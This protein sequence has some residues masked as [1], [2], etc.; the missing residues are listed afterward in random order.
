MPFFTA[1]NIDSANRIIQTRQPDKWSYEKKLDVE[2]QLG[3][4]FYKKSK[5]LFD[6]GHMV[7]RLDPCWGQRAAQAEIETFKF[8]NCVP[9]HSRLNRT[10]W[11][12]LEKNILEKGAI[13]KGGRI[14]VFAGPIFGEEEFYAHI[15]QKDIVFI[16]AMYWKIIVWK[17]RDRKLY[18]VGFVMSQWEFLKHDLKRTSTRSEQEADQYYENLKF[19]NDASYQVDIRAIQSLSKLRFPWKNVNYPY[20]KNTHTQLDVVEI[21][22]GNGIRNKKAGGLNFEILNLTL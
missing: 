6:K 21:L 19:K 4:T 11:L 7:R 10:I 1:V 17:K 16:P 2:F 15:N 9:Q 8:V 20:K 12:E 14:S 5:G 22:H 18:A 3:D 13:A